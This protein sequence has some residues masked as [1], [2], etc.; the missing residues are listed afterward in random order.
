[1]TVFSTKFCSNL[2]SSDQIIV[3][4]SDLIPIFS[5]VHPAFFKIFYR[6]LKLKNVHSTVKIRFKPRITHRLI[7]SILI[8]NQSQFKYKIYPFVAFLVSL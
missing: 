3:D 2:N 4:N 5:N 8:K 7:N 6:I 1:M